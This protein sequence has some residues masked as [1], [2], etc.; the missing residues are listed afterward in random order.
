MR[1][2]SIGLGCVDDNV[3][4]EVGQPLRCRSVVEIDPDFDYTGI[5][6]GCWI[7]IEDI[8]LEDHIADASDPAG[9]RVR[10]CAARDGSPLS[11]PYLGDI[12]F[13]D[14]RD[15]AHGPVSPIVSKG[16]VPTSSPGLT[17]MLR[18]RPSTGA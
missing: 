7:D 15:S 1:Q 16:P 12:G 17:L 6:A 10:Q 9:E 18:M 14:L 13:V 2:R 5:G 8:V 11:D 4:R 3:D